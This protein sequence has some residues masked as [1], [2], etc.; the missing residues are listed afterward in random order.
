MATYKNNELCIDNDCRRL[1]KNGPLSFMPWLRF[2]SLSILHFIVK[3]CCIIV[4]I[5]LISPL[6]IRLN[7][8]TIKSYSNS[9]KILSASQ[10]LDTLD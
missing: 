3:V 2:D 7:K 4:L 10:L 5:L 9:G 1:P 8:S 6:A